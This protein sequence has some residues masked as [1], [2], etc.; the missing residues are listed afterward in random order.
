M[1]KKSTQWFTRFVD[2]I[3]EV[4]PKDEQVIVKRLRALVLECLPKA[5]EKNTYGAPFYSHH[6]MI[7]FIWPPSLNWG[8]KKYTLLERGVTLGFCQGNLMSNEDGALLAENRKQM[9]CVY[10]RS[11]KDINESQVRSWLYESEL[12]D[13]SFAKRKRNASRKER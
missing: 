7:C 12:I 8:D 11:L 6:R 1:K 3:I 2:E 9:Y 4:F 13:E 10:Y 5:S